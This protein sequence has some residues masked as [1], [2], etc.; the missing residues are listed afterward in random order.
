MPAQIIDGQKIAARI[1]A[2]LVNEIRLLKKQTG[3]VPGLVNLIATDSAGSVAYANAQ[4][5]CAD[6]I[7]IH[8]RL[9]RLGTHVS[10]DE[11]I[12]Q[13]RQCNNDPQIHGIML[14]KPLPPDCEHH[15]SAHA[16]LPLKDVEGIHPENM[17]QI[18]S[19]R[20]AIVPCT[21]AAVMECLDSTGF[22]YYGKEAVVVGASE[23]VGLPLSL[24]LLQRLATV[25]VCHIATS[26]SGR[27]SEHVSRADLLIVAV[28]KPGLIKGEW[29]KPGAV[30][31][32]VGINNVN[33]RIMGD[34]EF[35]PAQQRASF[36]TPVPGGIGPVTVM[37]LMRNGVRACARQKK[38]ALNQV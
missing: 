24:M 38:I 15:L 32:D 2:E 17:G 36:I 9:I 35:H 6:K 27:L 10:Q 23:I 29:I 30:V 21:A 11:L 7:G 8:Y 26:E 18:F 16:I 4:K 1:Q 13:I 22:S 14:H 19:V 25:T 3:T 34:V 31:L 12:A 33:G 5:R 20:P 37:V 28:G